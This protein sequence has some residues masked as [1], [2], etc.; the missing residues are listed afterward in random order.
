LQQKHVAMLAYWEVATATPASD[1]AH[2][3]VV[4]T[5]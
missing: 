2:H 4:A 3:C 5:R 1:R